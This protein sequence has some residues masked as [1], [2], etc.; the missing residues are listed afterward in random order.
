MPPKPPTK[1]RLSWLFNPFTLITIAAIAIGTWETHAYWGYLFVRPK[2]VDKIND[3]DTVKS[4]GTLDRDESS[5][6]W[7][8]TAKPQLKIKTAITPSW[9]NVV[10]EADEFCKNTSR[11]FTSQTCLY[12]EATLYFDRQELITA[13]TPQLSSKALT[14]WHTKLVENVFIEIPQKQYQ[15]NDYRLGLVVVG[16]DSKKVPLVFIGLQGGQVENDHY[17]YYEIILRRKSK[18]P[19]KWEVIAERVFSIEIAGFEQM[20]YIVLIYS[21]VF[22]WGILLPIPMLLYGPKWWKKFKTE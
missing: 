6:D 17:P 10:K 7:K 4:W 1:S 3:F 2:L 21:I 20:D 18:K 22:W 19:V 14:R 16:R 11:F 13:K 12:D 8:N 5:I 9:E 15:D